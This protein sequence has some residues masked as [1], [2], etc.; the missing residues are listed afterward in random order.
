MFDKFS[1]KLS[2]E[3]K[4]HKEQQI[5]KL[6]ERYKDYK[7]PWGFDVEKVV[8]AFNLIYPV[9]KKY[10][11]IRVFGA[12][13]IED[14]PYIFA[15]NH[16]G[17]IPI[18][19]MMITIA[20]A[21][22][23][24]KPRVL[25][26]MVDSFL[27]GFPFLGSLTAQ[28]GSILGDRGNCKWLLDQGESILV[29][30]EGMKGITKSTHEFYDTRKFSNGFFRIALGEKTPIVPITV[31]GAE[32]MFP[33]VYHAKKLG[34]M[35]GLPTLPLTANLFPLPSPIDIYI[36]KPYEV[37]DDL[38]VDAQDKDIREHVY[39]IEKQINAQLLKGLKD[40]RP[41][42][43]EIRIPLADKFLKRR[44]NE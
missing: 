28:T 9:Y 27:A 36:G 17:Q 1:L 5:S 21:M 34:K 15:S 44:K 20:L 19:G 25:H 7:D 26:S 3:E 14:K 38:S 30:P 2:D 6:R 8:D 35:F 32:E 41:F 39:K 16:T 11:R 37:P 12:E 24:D 23:V 33:F 13:N 22:E 31:V 42:F 18:D 40:R 10:F 4:L 43:D 29:F